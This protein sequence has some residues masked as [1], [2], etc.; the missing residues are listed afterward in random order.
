VAAPLSRL[1]G[2]H[3]A[4]TMGGKRRWRQHGALPVSDVYRGSGMADE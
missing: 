4:E 1:Q 2:Y 3:Y